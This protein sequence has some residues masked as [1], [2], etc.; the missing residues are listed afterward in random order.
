MNMCKSLSLCRIIRSRSD[1]NQG[2]FFGGMKFNVKNDESKL[3][4]CTKKTKV[5]NHSFNH[6]QYQNINK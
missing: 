2:V 5:K 6:I 1:G 3:E 4:F